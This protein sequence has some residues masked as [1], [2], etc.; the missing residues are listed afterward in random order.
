MKYGD[1]QKIHEAGLITTD[2]RERIV[3]HYHLKEEGNKFLVIISFVGA[4]LVAAGLALLVAANWDAIPRGLKIFAGL[5]L[6]LGACG[7]GWWLREARG[8]A[9]ER[10][11]KR[12]W[13]PTP[14]PLLARPD[15]GTEIT[16]RKI[17]DAKS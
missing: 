15:I 14:I 10:P 7:G 11:A 5:A 9:I 13:L 16:I 6:M 17:E 8:K 2:Q 12:Q 4:V 3:A 1:I